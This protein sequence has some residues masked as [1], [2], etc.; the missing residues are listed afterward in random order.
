MKHD[1][2][3][4]NEYR[5]AR[6]SCKTEKVCKTIAQQRKYKLDKQKQDKKTRESN[7]WNCN[8]NWDVMY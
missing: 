6:C 5:V 7:V 3:T 8:S 4:D 2:Q 1:D